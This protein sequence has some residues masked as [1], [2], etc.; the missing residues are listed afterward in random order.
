MPLS[1]LKIKNAFFF[2][3]VFKEKNRERERGGGGWDRE[4]RIPSRLHVGPTVGLHLTTL[5]S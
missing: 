2:F 4:E 3:F 1:C 5:R